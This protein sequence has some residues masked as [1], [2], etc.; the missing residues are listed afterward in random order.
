MSSQF[1]PFKTVDSTI[2][3]LNVNQIAAVE[4]IGGSVRVKPY[5]KVYSAAYTFNIN[6]SEREK[7]LSLGIQLREPQ[8]DSDS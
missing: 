8:P 4:E 3:H 6:I 2:A 1:V 7:I 5:F